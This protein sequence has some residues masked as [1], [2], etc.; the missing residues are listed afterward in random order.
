M[1][2]LTQLIEPFVSN[3]ANPLTDGVCREGLL[4]AARS[5]PA[6]FRDGSDLAAREDMALASLFGGIALANARLGAVHGFAGIL[7]GA[8]G[9]P[10]GA[11]CARLL[12]FVMEANIR[13]AEARGEA[14]VLRRYAEVAATLTDDPAAAPRDGVTWVRRLCLEMR[15]PP[16]RNAGLST[17]DSAR[18]VPLVR[19]ASST[20]GNPVELSEEELT[21]VLEA[22][23]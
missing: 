20:R 2:A 17:S 9:H 3:A 23:L 21:R 1:D 12:A 16:L 18:L 22:A 4:R 15:I 13:A 6:V 5:L 8:T 14:A 10:H 19:R 7:G 11:L